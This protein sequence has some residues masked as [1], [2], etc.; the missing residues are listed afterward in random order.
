MNLTYYVVF[1]M[2]NDG[3]EYFAGRSKVDT[4]PHPQKTFSGRITSATP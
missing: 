1:K 4:V 2:G 3:K